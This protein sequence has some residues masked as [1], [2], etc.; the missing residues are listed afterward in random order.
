MEERL[1]S[2]SSVRRQ[3]RRKRI[4]RRL[5]VKVIVFGLLLLA[6]PFVHVGLYAKVSENGYQ[7]TDMVAKLRNLKAENELLQARLEYLRS[8]ERL[9]A[10]AQ[11][12]GMVI[13]DGYERIVLLPSVKMAKAER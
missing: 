5:L 8:P 4:S 11:K 1:S 7:R 12:Q 6:S 9:S 2:V 13:A 10:E 3:P